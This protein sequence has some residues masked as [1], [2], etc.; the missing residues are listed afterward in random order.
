MLIVAVLVSGTHDS[1]HG[2]SRVSSHGGILAA[3]AAVFVAVLIATHVVV[4]CDSS[5]GSL[6][7][8]TRLSDCFADVTGTESILLKPGNNSRHPKANRC[9]E[10]KVNY[11]SLTPL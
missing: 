8:D 6:H 4:P 10:Q 7:R 5:F 11:S 9:N 2:S 3:L 1:A